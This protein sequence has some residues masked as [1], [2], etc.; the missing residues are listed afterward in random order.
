MIP[1]NASNVGM[2]GSYLKQKNHANLLAGWFI[3]ELN[4][5]L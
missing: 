2:W 5:L 1:S 4:C 3:A